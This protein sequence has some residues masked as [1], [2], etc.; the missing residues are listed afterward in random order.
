[1]VIRSTRQSNLVGRSSETK[2]NKYQFTFVPKAP[3]QPQLIS[4]VR[5]YK[6]PRRAALKL[7][8]MSLAEL[9][10]L[11]DEVQT[12]LSG[13]IQM[14]REELQR[15]LKELS[16]VESSAGDGR[17]EVRLGRPRKPADGG[18]AGNGKNHP[19]KGRT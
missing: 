17:P 8:A 13:K 2:F 4:Q 19:L 18:R 1:M 5:R 12:A 6:M 16:N 14:E 15:K 11:R 10:Q 9:R 7:D 3:I